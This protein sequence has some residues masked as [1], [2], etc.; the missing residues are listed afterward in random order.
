MIAK[1][2]DKKMKHIKREF[3]SYL[4]ELDSGEQYRGIPTND[5]VAGE[6]IVFQSQLPKYFLDVNRLDPRFAKQLRIFLDKGLDYEELLY[7]YGRFLGL[8][9]ATQNKCDGKIIPESEKNEIIELEVFDSYEF[10][11]FDLVFI[12]TDQYREDLIYGTDEYFDHY[13]VN[14]NDGFANATSIFI[15]K[16]K[17]IQN[18]FWFFFK[19]KVELEPKLATEKY[20]TYD[21][22]NLIGKGITFEQLEDQFGDWVSIA[23]LEGTM[24]DYGQLI[25]LIG[26]LKSNQEKSKLIMV[27]ERRS[28][29]SSSKESNVESK[30]I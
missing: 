12:A 26:M 14:D 4:F 29:W 22:S 16:K 21:L 1:I 25:G 3:K 2:S 18:F 13:L 28:Y 20:P 19:E 15:L 7:K 24:D 30:P 9:W 17:N 23:G 5:L 8:E 27:V 10:E 11:T 6:I